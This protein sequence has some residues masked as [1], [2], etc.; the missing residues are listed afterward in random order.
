[1]SWFYI[2]TEGVL[3]KL[4]ADKKCIGASLNQDAFENKTFDVK[5]GDM[6]YVFTDGYV[7]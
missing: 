5:T 6:L 2:I 7:D 4:T 3:Q 1:M